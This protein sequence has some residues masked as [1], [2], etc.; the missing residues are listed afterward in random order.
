LVN[1]FCC[2]WDWNA[3]EWVVNRWCRNRNEVGFRRGVILRTW[4]LDWN[5]IRR[6]NDC[7]ELILR[8]VIARVA[9]EDSLVDQARASEV[10]LP[11]KPRMIV[12]ETATIAN[13]E[14]LRAS[15]R[16]CCAA[17]R[18]HLKYP[19]IIGEM[20]CCACST[21]CSAATAYASS[22]NGFSNIAFCGFQMIASR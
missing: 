19:A 4:V 2:R 21:F 8:S 10:E 17:M 7:T 18:S 9:N 5:R 6:D 13:C 16:Y 1:D 22:A 20:Y 11:L 3:R 12:Q 14:R 15:R